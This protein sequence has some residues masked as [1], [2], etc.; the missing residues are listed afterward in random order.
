MGGCRV[1]TADSG[2]LMNSLARKI[3]N[4][5]HVHVC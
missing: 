3:R 4:I 2:W 5:V 1:E